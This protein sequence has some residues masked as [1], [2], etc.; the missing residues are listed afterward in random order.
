[1][2]VQGRVVSP[3]FPFSQYVNQV[4]NQVLRGGRR[5]EASKSLDRVAVSGP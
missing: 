4:M 3:L 2:G 1:M 5:E